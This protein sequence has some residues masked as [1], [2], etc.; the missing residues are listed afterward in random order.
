MI[1]GEENIKAWEYMRSAVLKHV[2]EH[3]GKKSWIKS[4]IKNSP[5]LGFADG[6]AATERHSGPRRP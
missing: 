6:K 3:M 1:G 2:T 4:S 5:L